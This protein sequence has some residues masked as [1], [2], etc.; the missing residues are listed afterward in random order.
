MPV[1]PPSIPPISGGVSLG[2]LA[3]LINARNRGGGIGDAFSS[4]LP[5]MFNFY[6]SSKL[7]E[8]RQEF[9]AEESERSFERGARRD[10]TMNL[11][12]GNIVRSPDNDVLEEM[13]KAL[14]R[15]GMAAGA[16]D[17]ATTPYELPAF[18]TGDIP[19]GAP[20]P[21]VIPRTTLEA[22]QSQAAKERVITIRKPEAAK[23]SLDPKDILYSGT[24]QDFQVAVNSG[25]FGALVR[26]DPERVDFY[27]DQVDVLAKTL[28][29]GKGLAKLARESV[30]GDEYV[31]GDE[32]ADLTRLVE[33]QIEIGRT[34]ASLEASRTRS[35]LALG[36]GMRWV[37]SREQVDDRGISTQLTPPQIYVG[38]ALAAGYL[39]A[40]PEMQAMR[41]R[42]P[43]LSQMSDLEFA[44]FVQQ[45]IYSF[46]D[47]PLREKTELPRSV[48]AKD[49]E[50]LLKAKQNV[51][52]A[53]NQQ[54][55]SSVALLLEKNVAAGRYKA[56]D[57]QKM[58][59]KRAGMNNLDINP[60]A[61]NSP[62]GLGAGIARDATLGLLGVGYLLSKGITTYRQY[63]EA[64]ISRPRDMPPL[65][66]TL[67][68]GSST[69]V[70]MLMQEL[71]PDY[72]FSAPDAVAISSGAGGNV[73][74]T[75]LT[76]RD[77]TSLGLSTDALTAEQYEANIARVADSLNAAIQT[78]QA[79]GRYRV[80]VGGPT[81]AENVA[82]EIISAADSSADALRARFSEIGDSIN[83]ILED[84]EITA[85]ERTELEE[86]LEI[87]LELDR[88]LEVGGD[89]VAVNAR[90][91]LL[92]QLL[93]DFQRP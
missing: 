24:A 70:H 72:G 82:A 61:F 63:Q 50:F 80:G 38:G 88:L 57:V 22:Y 87:Y 60:S 76:D 47:K 17:A 71:N 78:T 34:L 8:E 74:S 28:P 68:G 85:A 51:R 32:L 40:S 53:E 77:P 66:N 89:S 21:R 39:P 91:I 6:F 14:Q 12:T 41:A 83:A 69:A 52:N 15:G 65:E 49:N 75:L 33:N 67:L 4:L 48:I 37:M 84:G 27:L 90:R 86:K 35:N 92:E 58:L 2:G 13:S 23:N 10:F 20:T 62:T 11:A 36:A 43:E 81:E 25:S 19:E 64:L 31:T 55:A 5:Q 79:V 44:T 7:Q 59:A 26:A 30:E 93:P 29:G 46:S 18:I 9:Q 54:L 3:S 1:R 16:A 42:S 56:Q 73:D 45:T